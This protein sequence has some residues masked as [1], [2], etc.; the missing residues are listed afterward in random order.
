MIWTPSILP[1]HFFAEIVFTS[2]ARSAQS[3]ILEPR[4]PGLHG[5][6]RCLLYQVPNFP[7]SLIIGDAAVELLDRRFGGTIKEVAIC[8]EFGRTCVEACGPLTSLFN[9]GT[10]FA[11]PIFNTNPEPVRALEQ[12][13]CT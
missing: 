1:T 10:V 13:K 7:I 6:P 3:P 8:D 5:F 11:S 12:R 9:D 2:G 4:N